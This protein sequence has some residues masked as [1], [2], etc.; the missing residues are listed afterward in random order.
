MTPAK[1]LFSA[2]EQIVFNIAI[3]QALNL[4]KA[5][6]GEAPRTHDEFMTKIVQEQQITLPQLPAGHRYVYDPQTE[7]LMVE[8][9]KK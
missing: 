8:R 9:P 2:R 3:P 4:Y 5:S 6:N 7:Q 1:T